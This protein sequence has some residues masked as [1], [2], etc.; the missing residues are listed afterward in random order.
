MGKGMKRIRTSKDTDSVYPKLVYRQ[1]S[2]HLG[3]AQGSRIVCP[4]SDQPLARARSLAD[5]SRTALGRL[6]RL[7]Y[8]PLTRGLRSQLTTT[9]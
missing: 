7:S 9:S 5:R 1:H 3:E 6:N 2:V 8:Q 4:R